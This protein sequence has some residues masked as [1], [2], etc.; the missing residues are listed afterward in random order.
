MSAAALPVAS[1]DLPDAAHSLLE[2]VKALV[3][4]LVA[5]F[6]QRQPSRRRGSH[7]VTFAESSPETSKVRMGREKPRNDSSPTS[8]LTT[9]CSAAACTR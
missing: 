2:A 4:F 1:H 3:A 8:R 9:N 7:E 5:E 6:C